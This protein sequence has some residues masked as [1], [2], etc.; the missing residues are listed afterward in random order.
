MLGVSVEWLAGVVLLSVVQRK[1][2]GVLVISGGLT[3]S[4]HQLKVASFGELLESSK[5]SFCDFSPRSLGEMI[6]VDEHIFQSGGEKP[7]T[8]FI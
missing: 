6:Q 5:H 8:G 7:P 4:T 2:I 1:S 3:S